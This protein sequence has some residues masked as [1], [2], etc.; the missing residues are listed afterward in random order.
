[1]C[2]GTVIA[3]LCFLIFINDLPATIKNSFAG[4]FCDDTLIAKEIQKEEDTEELQKDLKCVEN[5]T[6]TWG[7][8]FNV[9]KCY[10]LT[11]TNRRRPILKQYYLNNM[12][13]KKKD[14]IK[15][16]GI[17][18]DNKITFKEH[19]A[20]TCKKAQTVLNMI[21]R[22]LYF[23]PRKVKEKACLATVRPILEFASICWSPNCLNLKKKLEIVQNNCA[24]FVTN[25]YPKKG[26][27][28]LFSI[29]KILKS[30][31]WDSLEN[32]RNQARL[33]MAY[34]ILN[35]HVILK[36][37]CLPKKKASRL[38]R[39]NMAQEN[40]LEERYSRLVSTEK[41]FLLQCSNSVE[42]HSLKRTSFGPLH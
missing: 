19:I 32:R 1:M 12:V 5:W 30:L 6:E 39:T 38:P 31:S 42:Q 25:S 14:S 2:Q 40:K 35:K 27:Y 17:T 23:A 10:K 13:I 36:P 16:L 4:I 37:E 21:R 18:I 7:M 22:N 28:E 24:K 15:Y 41:N 29:T 9:I 3:A 33:T 11:V 26:Q 20:E 8:K 34:K